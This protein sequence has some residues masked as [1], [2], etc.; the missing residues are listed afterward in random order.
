MKIFETIENVFQ[1][2]LEKQEVGGSIYEMS[3]N[4]PSLYITKNKEEET[5]NLY[6]IDTFTNYTKIVMEISENCGKDITLLFAEAYKL[7]EMDNENIDEEDEEINKK[8]INFCTQFIAHLAHANIQSQKILEYIDLFEKGNELSLE[9][10]GPDYC[11]IVIAFH[12]LLF[13]YTSIIDFIA[14]KRHLNSEFIRGMSR[15]FC[16]IDS[17]EF[18]SIK[19][20]FKVS[21][22]YEK[23]EETP[24][25]H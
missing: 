3:H 8:I 20:M 14:I 22:C 17:T 9:I 13:Y 19:R 5:N 21:E 6:H 24:T 10:K 15:R 7:Y 2:E 11:F 25:I 16:L 4:F 23:V 18:E 12:N 1:I